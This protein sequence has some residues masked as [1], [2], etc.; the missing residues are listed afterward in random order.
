MLCFHGDRFHNTVT[1]EGARS[2]GVRISDKVVATQKKK[3]R[4]DTE[5]EKGDGK[6]GGFTEGDKRMSD[7]G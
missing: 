4:G 6:K 5:Q 7:S 1:F 2:A 3:P